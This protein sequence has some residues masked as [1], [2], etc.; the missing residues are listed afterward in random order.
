MYHNEIEMSSLPMDT[1]PRTAV[2][3]RTRNAVLDAAASALARNP[4]ATMAQV[5]EA[6]Q[7]AR[8]TVHRHFP[9]RESLLQALRQRAQDEVCAAYGRVGDDTACAGILRVAQAFFE[10]A[11][12]LIAAYVTLPQADQLAAFNATDP[13]MTALVDQGRVD[14]SIDSALHSAWIGQALWGLLHASWKIAAT[15]TM[16]RYDAQ[17]VLL[18]ALRKLLTPKQ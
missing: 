6:A 12:L 16:S 17:A 10:R 5:A 13:F 1:S 9:E 18:D 7:M 14:G 15:G 8:S 2:S 11:D 4:G 3:D